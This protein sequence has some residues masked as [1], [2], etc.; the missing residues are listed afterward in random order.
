MKWL[1]L[2]T[3]QSSAKCNMEFDI[4][5]LGCLKNLERPILRFYEWESNSATYGYFIQPFS[6]LKLE[7][8]KKHHLTLA[9]RPT[10]GGIIFH[11]ADFTFSLLLPA[12]HPRFSLNT[13]EN[14]AFVNQLVIKS[15]GPFLKKEIPELLN[16]DHKSSQTNT[17]DEYF[18]MAKPTKFDVMVN[19]RKVGGAAQRRTKEGYLHQGSISLISPPEEFLQD[20]LQSESY[21]LEAMRKNSYFLL[22]SSAQPMEIL[23]AKMEIKRLI[24]ETFQ[25]ID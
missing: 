23:E 17:L 1:V 5:L 20:L 24:S 14:Y 15:L 21:L 25:S 8:V 6:F 19:G 9:R 18:C 2:N 22:P 7:G 11:V 12:N 3:G 13:L 4:N 10:G 16:S